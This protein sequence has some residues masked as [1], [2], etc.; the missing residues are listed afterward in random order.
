M[1]LVGT[2]DVDAVEQHPKVTLAWALHGL[3]IALR[4][5]GDGPAER[6]VRRQ[7]HQLMLAI[8]RHSLLA[9]GES[10]EEPAVERAGDTRQE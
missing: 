3:E 7:F 9:T 5:L 2:G 6:R 10:S 1:T 4:N 8:E